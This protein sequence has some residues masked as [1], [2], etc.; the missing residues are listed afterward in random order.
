MNREDLVIAVYGEDTD[1]SSKEYGL[2]D[3]F[4]KLGIENTYTIADCAQ[5]GLSPQLAIAF[6]KTQLGDWQKYLNNRVTSVMWSTSSVFLDNYEIVEQFSGFQNFVLFHSCIDDSEA[7][8]AYL[9]KSI[10]GYIP[11]SVNTD[12]WRPSDQEKDINYSFIGNIIDYDE[13]LDELKEKMPE[14][15]FG[16]MSN[17]IDV[18]INQSSFSLWQIYQFFKQEGGIELT[19]EQYLLIARNITEIISAKKAI[20]MLSQMGNKP[21]T[22]MGEGNWEKY[23]KNPNLTVLKNTDNSHKL[24]LL[25]RTKILIH[26]QPFE[27]SGGIDET[28]LHAIATKTAVLSLPQKIFGV[29]FPNSIIYSDTTKFENLETE[30]EYY[31]E[32]EKERNAFVTNAF[33]ILTAK[34]QWT[35]RAQNILDIIQ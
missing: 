35:N 7:I 32:N 13:K 31:I 8:K 18:A 20:Q 33:N 16:L 27:L 2:I 10:H 22:I 23:L 29:E 17:F 6:D 24:E 25:Q 26:S 1:K 9:P 21:L 30:A 12:F 34:Y 28:V 3:A 19:D 11:L 15:V 4:R 14:L 5:K